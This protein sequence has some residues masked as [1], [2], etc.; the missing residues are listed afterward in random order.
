MQRRIRKDGMI[1]SSVN[2]AVVVYFTEIAVLA[3]RHGEN[4]RKMSTLKD[5]NVTRDLQ[6]TTSD[7]H[8]WRSY[9]R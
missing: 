2:K 7:K 1:T 3:W 5:E 6:N 9:R 8:Y 4:P